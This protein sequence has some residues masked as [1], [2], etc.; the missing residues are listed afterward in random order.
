MPTRFPDVA[1]GGVAAGVAANGGTTGRDIVVPAEAGM[2]ETGVTGRDIVA[3]ADGAAAP[4]AGRIPVVEAGDG[5]APAPERI[6]VDESAA[7]GVD[8]AAELGPGALA[9]AAAAAVAAPAPAA[10]S[11]V[12]HCTQNFA[13]D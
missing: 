7:G 6:P 10:G 4:A 5:G 3:E 8:F 9:G 1:A 11:V 2:L 12:P 13:P